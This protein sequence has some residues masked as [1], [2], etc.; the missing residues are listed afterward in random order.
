MMQDIGV[1]QARPG[2]LEQARKRLAVLTLLSLAA[3]VVVS[4]RLIWVMGPAQSGGDAHG[5]EMIEAVPQRPEIRD[6]NGVLLAVNVDVPS[7]YADPQLIPDPDEAAKLLAQVLPDLDP[8]EIRRRIAAGGRFLWI[9]R[10]VAPADLKAVNAL[11]IPGI[12]YRM[13]TKRVYPSGRIAAHVVGY[14]SV[15]DTGIAGI[16]AYLD[17]LVRQT[18]PGGTEAVRLSLDIR[19]Q[20]LLHASLLRAIETYQAR[21]AAGLVLDVTNGEVVALVSLP[22]F[23]PN[24][25]AEALDPQRINRLNVGVYE[26]GSTFKALTTAMALNSELFTINSSL[27]ARTPLR[28]GRFSINDYRGE[29]RILSLPE[30]FIYSSN[31]AMARMALAVGAERQKAFL[32][33]MGQFGKLRTEL[34]ETAQPIVPAQWGEVTTATVAFGHGIAVAPLQAAMAVAALV[35]GGD[36]ITP[37]FI[38]GAEVGSRRVARGVV[39]PETGEALRYLMRLNAERGSAKKADVAGYMVGGK[40]GTAEKVVDGRYARNRSLTAFMGIAPA[41]APRYLFLT[42]LDEPQS[43]PDSYGF[44]TAGWNAAPVTGSIMTSALP[45]LGEVPRFGAVPQAFPTMVALGAWG[46]ARDRDGP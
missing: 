12:D 22:D 2:N 44:A 1:S 7:I 21:A 23:D 27:D 43:T 24:T 33:L 42:I 41:D 45:M 39:T 40:T 17:Q 36:L 28:F 38:A 25:P 29:K 37:T 3:F 18:G 15:D 10:Q 31:I 16:E 9:K 5:V 26:M 19:V 32:G 46:S 6:R 35:N 13:E 34:P 14:T 8:V 20:A 4:A 11:G 30:A